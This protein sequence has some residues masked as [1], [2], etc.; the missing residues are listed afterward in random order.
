MRVEVYPPLVRLH[1][2]EKKYPSRDLTHKNTPA[3]DINKCQRPV[4][5][6]RAR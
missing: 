2:L 5:S 1:G 4:R 6:R 3:P